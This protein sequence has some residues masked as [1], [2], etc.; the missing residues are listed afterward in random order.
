M[1]V[2]VFWQYLSAA[3]GF[4]AGRM[5]ALGR[6]SWIAPVVVLFSSVTT[7]CTCGVLFFSPNSSSAMSLFVCFCFCSVLTWSTSFCVGLF[8]VKQKDRARLWLMSRARCVEE[9]WRWRRR[10]CGRVRV[11]FVSLGY[12]GCRC[13]FLELAQA[14]ARSQVPVVPVVDDFVEGFCV[15]EGRGL[16]FEER[17]GPRRRRF[18][19]VFPVADGF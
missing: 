1:G 19:E 17:G 12:R 3:L 2:P 11:K 5:C 8:I 14:L 7:P 10:L 13:V 16:P 18:E 6:R 9:G 15:H 4:L